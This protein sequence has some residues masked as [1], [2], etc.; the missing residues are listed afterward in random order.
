MA[1]MIS[2]NLSS[3]DFMFVPR[4]IK[5]KEIT[6][7]IPPKPKELKLHESIIKFFRKNKISGLVITQ[8]HVIY[9]PIVRFYWHD[10]DPIV[11]KFLENPIFTTD[12]TLLARYTDVVKYRDTKR[13]IIS[14]MFKKVERKIDCIDEI[15]EETFF[16]FI[17]SP[18][19]DGYTK[20]I[21]IA[22]KLAKRFEEITLD[23]DNIE[24]VL[25]DL[26]L[27]FS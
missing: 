26:A 18:R 1:K 6:A 20:R 19:I 16:L 7:K 9:G 14:V 13:W 17:V 23:E 10:S 11:K 22:Q 2:F 21:L 4:T 8:M 25:E 5:E 3:D 12:A 15:V 27:N 24:R